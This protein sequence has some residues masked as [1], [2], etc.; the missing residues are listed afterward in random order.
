[1]NWS[2][3]KDANS[4]V[5]LNDWGSLIMRIPIHYKSTAFI[6]NNLI[7]G[8]KIGVLERFKLCTVKNEVQKI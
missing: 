4:I 2:K 6:A 8:Q 7:F 3:S 5:E 1:M